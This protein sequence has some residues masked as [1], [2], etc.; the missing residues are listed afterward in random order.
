MSER[1]DNH[2]RDLASMLDR[3]QGE[4]VTQILR[5]DLYSMSECDFSKLVHLTNKYEKNGC[6]DD[7]TINPYRE[8]GGP[9]EHVSVEL[10]R[11][12][13]DGTPIVYAETIQSWGNWPGHRPQVIDTHRA[14]PQ[15][16]W[17]PYE[18]PYQRA[19]YQAWGSHNPYQGND[20]FYQDYRYQRPYQEFQP[21][22]SHHRG[23][24]A[25][26]FILPALLGIGLGA[27]FSLGRQNNYNH[28]NFQPRPYF[29][30]QTY[31]RAPNYY[32][33]RRYC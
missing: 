15:E 25:E 28:H 3:G 7:L 11:R 6:G 31:N 29:Y 10:N 8:K 30:P 18:Q 12:H 1:I 14:R 33:Q 22:H 13:Q 23:L 26:E 32:Q 4:R 17:D 24:R 21:H 5:N 16:G 2:A 9:K 19:G 27:A 20:R